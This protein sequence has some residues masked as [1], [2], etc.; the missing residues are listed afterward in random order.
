[1]ETWVPLAIVSISSLIL[2]VCRCCATEESSMNES[3]DIQVVHA[4]GDSFARRGMQRLGEPEAAPEGPPE[5]WMRMFT[6]PEDPKPA[7]TLRL[8][9]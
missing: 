4:A 5:A 3:D 7:S 2:W 8:L 6:E 9:T 1:M